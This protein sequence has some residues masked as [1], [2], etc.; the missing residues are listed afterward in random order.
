[1]VN[2]NISQGQVVQN[3]IFTNLALNQLELTERDACNAK[4]DKI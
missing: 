1:M 4:T 3:M 2:W